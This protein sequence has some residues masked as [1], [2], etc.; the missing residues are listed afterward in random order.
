MPNLETCSV[1]YFFDSQIK[2]CR[3]NRV[4]EL[5]KSR[6]CFGLLNLLVANCQ[7]FLSSLCYTGMGWN[8]RNLEF[9][10]VISLRYELSRKNPQFVAF[11]IFVK[12]LCG[13]NHNND[14]LQRVKEI[15]RRCFS[16][17]DTGILGKRNFRVLPTGVKE[18][19]PQT[20]CS[21]PT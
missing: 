7:V 14:S 13:I 1:A 17:S 15:E 9:R 4:V 19:V 5:F 18:I 12:P 16:V 11:N 6:Y 3:N 21:T 10:L 2:H 20:N 8:A